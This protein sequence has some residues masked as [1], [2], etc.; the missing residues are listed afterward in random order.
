MPCLMLKG[1]VSAKLIK[2]VGNQKSGEA[3]AAQSNW[4][5]REDHAKASGRNRERGLKAERRRG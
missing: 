5:S 3:G 1:V 4:L 2:Q